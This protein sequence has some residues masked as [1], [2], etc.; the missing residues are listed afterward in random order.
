MKLMNRHLH[1][2]TFRNSVISS[3]FVHEHD[4]EIVESVHL[5]KQHYATIHIKISAFDCVILWRECFSGFPPDVLQLLG[6]NCP[7][8]P[9][10]AL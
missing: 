9:E 8:L 7:W 3:F 2:K 4:T 10:S 1:T 5:L 6:L